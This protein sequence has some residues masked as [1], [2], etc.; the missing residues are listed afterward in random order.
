MMHAGAVLRR[1]T[2][3]AGVR[4][5]NWTTGLPAAILIGDVVVIALTI[6]IGHSV[7]FG[8]G[9][10]D[11][12]GVPITVSY[13]A[14]GVILGTMWFTSLSVGRTREIRIVGAGPIEYKRVV[15]ASLSLFGFIAI[16]AYSF[17]VELARGYLII[18]CTVGIVLL[19]AWRWGFRRF[20]V[21]RRRHGAYS[22]RLAIIGQPAEVLQ[23]FK[24][25][26]RTPEAGYVPVGALMPGRSFS[27]PTGVELPLPVLS[28]D[29]RVSA[30]I[31]TLSRE[32][33]DVVAV[34]G[35]ALKPAAMRRL[36]WEL[37]NLNIS[38]LLAPALTD[39]AGPR[40]H[41]LPLADLPL[42]HVSTPELGGVPSAIKRSIDIVGSAVGLILISPLLLAVA[43]A[44]KLDDG[45]PVL[46]AQ[47]RVGRDGREFTMFKF[48]SM[49]VDAEARLAELRE[50]SEGNDVLFKM[51][52]DPRITKVGAFIRRYSIDEL[53]QLINVLIGE[54]SL[55]GP[56][57]PLRSEV[58]QYEDHVM[59]RLKVLPGITGLWQVGGRSDLDWEES[60]RLD[61]YYVENWSIV[62]DVIILFRTIRVVLARDG[63]Y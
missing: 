62:Q 16:L 17:S 22:R 43:I 29:R 19:L 23:L 24:S 32:N 45:G 40:I 21:A 8:V 57:P 53:P 52:E 1:S 42:I 54:M 3:E 14:I 12:A 61:L 39:V 30:M 56:R 2:E 18:T 55:V 28:V 34:T 46:F 6:L 15:N 33:V 47:P 9:T 50:S 26:E 51:R 7:R 31:E 10:S 35:G 11:L 49:V 13:G 25:F 27:S 37:A 48:R 59:R 41:A 44:I 20:V 63:A 60:V 5:R 38:L 4:Q 36:S 58:E